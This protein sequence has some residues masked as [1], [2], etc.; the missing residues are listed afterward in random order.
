MKFS[1]NSAAAPWV[2]SIAPQT[3]SSAGPSPSNSDRSGASDSGRPGHSVDRSPRRRCLMRTVPAA[4]SADKTS[5]SD[6]FAPAN[7][8]KATETLVWNK[9]GAVSFNFANWKNANATR[10]LTGSFTWTCSN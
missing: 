8:T 9:S 6:P 10:N 7:N 1:V 5:E 2:W 4:I 3:P